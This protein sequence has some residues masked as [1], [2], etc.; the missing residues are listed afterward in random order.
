MGAVSGSRAGITEPATPT[1]QD[2]A[3]RFV[4]S[5]EAIEDKEQLEVRITT[6]SENT[7]WF[8]VFPLREPDRLVFDLPN[9]HWEPGLTAHLDSAHPG[10]KEIRAGQFSDDPPITRLVFELTTPVEEL[11][12]RTVAAQDGGGLRVR[13]ADEAEAHTILT[14]TN[15][16]RTAS[17]VPTVEQPRT[18]PT[19]ATPVAAEP[20]AGP[21][22]SVTPAPAAT[23]LS[24]VPTPS[25]TEAIED[26]DPIP[27]GA[28]LGAPEL[29][30]PELA[31]REPLPAL[32]PAIESSGF[33][34]RANLPRFLGAVALLAI[35]GVFA[36]WLRRRF[37]S[38]SGDEAVVAEAAIRAP[39]FS[40]SPQ[41]PASPDVIRCRI[42]DGYLVLAP[43]GGRATLDKLTGGPQRARVEG[44]VEISPAELAPAA[45]Q[46][47][48]AERQPFSE[49]V[50]DAG[51]PGSPA[52]TAEKLVA[53]LSDDDVTV[54]K[55]AAQG[56]WT[57]ADGGRTDILLPYLENDDPRVRLVTA[58]VLGEAGASQCSDALAKLLSDPD[59]SVRASAVYA[60]SQLGPAVSKHSDAVR[61]LLSDSEDLVRARAV[62]ALAALNP[63]SGDCAREIMALTSDPD[64]T[65]RQ[66]AAESTLTYVERGVTQAMIDVLGDMTQRAQALELLQ[67]AEDSTLRRLLLA[68]KM[69][70]DEDN[71]G[72]LDT[73]SYV[74][75]ARWTSDDLADDLQSPEETVRLAALE[76]LAV[77]GGEEAMM[78]VV[79]LA[80]T[81]PSS[82]VKKRAAEILEASHDLTRQTAGS[83]ADTV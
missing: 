6:T 75:S 25:V 21:D 42:I 46:E 26:P 59:P 40:S 22:E 19:S 15:R 34:W 23:A 27:V 7:P 8:S 18:E 61:A 28:Q 16:P 47:P 12:Y 5:V 1:A 33:S 62:E 60:F 65:V 76:G 64:S 54:R 51:L 81:D 41:G 4:Q 68:A 10:V 9:F 37:Q 83:H 36:F 20:A 50:P 35:V 71:R 70:A 63:Q 43:E 80:K 38:S 13:V 39:Q 31:V 66:A 56:L 30:R 52:E 11:R 48:V 77:I 72:P 53:A 44:S 32:P 57:L 17:A 29:T 67:R 45:S 82:D 55:S 73:L 14:E 49:P 78:H 2:R 74:V 58:G 69:A 24:A 3:L 79:R